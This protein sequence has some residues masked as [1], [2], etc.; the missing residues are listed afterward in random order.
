VRD[1][2]AAIAALPARLRD[3]LVALD[4]AGL[5]YGE[6]AYALRVREGTLAS[7]VFSA[8]SQLAT[9]LSRP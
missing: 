9:S 5:S 7:R 2:F 6:A 3:A 8:R 4:V 1:A